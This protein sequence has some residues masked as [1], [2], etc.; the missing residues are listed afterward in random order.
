MLGLLL[1]TGVWLYLAFGA[2]MAPEAAFLLVTSWLFVYYFV[3]GGII[4][5]KTLALNIA[6]AR[7][8]T[9]QRGMIQSHLGQLS[10]HF[11]GMSQIAMSSGAVWALV[12]KSLVLTA[13]FVAM[14]VVGAWFLAHSGTVGQ[15][16]SQFNHTM[17]WVGGGLLLL[18][19][20]Q[21]KR[22]HRRNSN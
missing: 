19:V 15:T 16:F 10:R 5:V 6:G 7:R 20:I 3:T 13:I 17:L 4:F 9:S 14:F 22:N 21:Q 12:V 11:A 1:G 8:L 18:G 2:N